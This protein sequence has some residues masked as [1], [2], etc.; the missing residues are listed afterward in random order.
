MPPGLYPYVMKNP[1]RQRSL[2]EMAD[3][4]INGDRRRDRFAEGISAAEKPDCVRPDAGT[5]AG[6]LNLVLVPL[7]AAR[8]KCK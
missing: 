5:G 4:Q 2:A 6:L 7:A 8:D 3:E 1:P